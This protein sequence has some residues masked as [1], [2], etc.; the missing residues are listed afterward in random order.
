LAELGTQ[1]VLDEAARR[2]EKITDKGEL[3]NKFSLLKALI[4]K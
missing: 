1:N 4:N 2:F 3:L